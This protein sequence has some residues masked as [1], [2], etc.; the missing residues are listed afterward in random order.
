MNNIINIIISKYKYI[1]IAIIIISIP[2]G[3]YFSQQ[4]HLNQIDVYFDEDDREIIL[5]NKFQ[6]TYGNEEFIIIAF[7]AKNIF[8]KKNIQIIRKLTEALKVEKGVQRVFTIT[9]AGESIGIGDTIKYKKI[10]PDQKLNKKILLDSR[11][12]AL[13]NKNFVNFL[14]SKDGTTTSLFIEIEPLPYKEKRALLQKIMKTS[15]QISGENIKLH[16][17]G[18]PF[19][20]V[21]L[22][23][24]SKVDF[25]TFTPITFVLIFFIV[26][27]MLKNITLSLLCQL[28][29]L[30]AL[31]FS[32]S[33]FVFC[34]ESFNLVTN[35]MGA[36]L[37]AISVAD[38]IHLLSQYRDDLI[39]SGGDNRWAI[40]NAT[41]HVWFPC[42]FTSLTTGIGFF[43]FIASSIRPPK[44]LGI[45]TASGVMIAFILTIT[46][47]P[48]C[49][50]FFKKRIHIK[51]NTKKNLD[52]NNRTPDQLTKILTKIGILTT[53]HYRYFIILFL[54]VITSSIFGIFMMKFE[55]NTINYLP[56]T[57]R[58]RSDIDFIEKNISGTI[59]YVLL[60]KAKSSDF[61]YTHPESLRLINK[62]QSDFM[63]E[64]RQFSSSFSIA[65]YFK[66][67]NK[68]FN[69]GNPKFY[70]I[71]EN[72]R[73]IL[74][75]YEI[76]DTEIFDRLITPDYMETRISIQ[77]KCET[78]E[79]GYNIYKYITDY[80]KSELGKN[81]SYEIT[82]LSTLYVEMEEK[83]K[84]SQLNSLSLAFIIIFF[85]M[86]II[87]RN[88]LLA[89][90]SMIPNIFPIALTLG[91]MGW[92]NIPMDVATVMIAS[93]TI[94]IAVDDTI[95]F[96]IWFRRN[97]DSGKDTKTAIVQT[98]EDVG[99][100]I[101]I[102]TV[103][104]FLAFFV[105]ILGHITPTRIFGVL[106]AFSM[107]F[108]LIG[109]LFFLP[110]LIML[111]KPKFKTK[112]SPPKKS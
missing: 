10:I 55:T 2:A 64:I 14:I 32:I 30:F 110:A 91:F 48:A 99:K 33:F 94:G 57:N 40:K 82:G 61:D 9:E 45:F 102:T 85:M 24:L 69:K 52:Y 19:A 56:A 43:S 1:L 65:N 4:K 47:L 26:L 46:F 108:A 37:L 22:N 70:K 90:L 17:G 34:V 54:I 23:H 96:I 20:E 105:L 21:E 76:G 66:E 36:I 7:K 98:F 60:I 81:F 72:R 95:H 63:R 101:T 86:L 92:F 100:P 62:I 13:K 16:Y 68:A 112:S 18:I 73:D 58:I 38:S 25:L 79:E 93:I 29:I 41:S 77:L 44:I 11:E 27:F 50:V 51:Q 78:N 8:T 59:P 111:F 15:K 107:I 39:K 71:P 104:L 28:N 53:K 80:L 12:R 89:L 74:D 87:C 97:I 106:T 109:D 6:E 103:V 3:Y 31:F 88:L 49:I 84:E 83:L 5:Y 67:V 75:F 42:L 35:I